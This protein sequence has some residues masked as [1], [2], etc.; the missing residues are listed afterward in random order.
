MAS[1]CTNRANSTKP[2][3]ITARL[4]VGERTLPRHTGNLGH[5]L[6][7]LGNLD[8]AF[9]SYAEALRL[10]PDYADAHFNR[11]MALLLQGHF[12]EGWAEYDWRWRTAT[13][14]TQRQSRAAVAQREWDGSPLEGRSILLHAEQ[15]LGDTIQFIRYVSL[16]KQQGAGKVMLACPPELR[17]LMEHCPGIR[18]DFRRDAIAP[19]R[20]G[21]LSSEPAAS[22]WN[23]VDQEHIPAM[24]PYIE[25]DPQL[26]EKWEARL[27]SQETERP[28]LRVGIAWQGNPGHKGDL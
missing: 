20:R 25:S 7:D 5:A 12:A 16:V 24:I 28:R 22:V 1:P 3:S 9:A 10:K 26:V 2:L 15:G 4:C 27:A 19:I 6:R 13:Y 14:L 21:C 11:S 18:S 8:E 23:D 17:R